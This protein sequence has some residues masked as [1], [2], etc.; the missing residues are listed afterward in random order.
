MKKRIF[1]ILIAFSCAIFAVIN[2]K[3]VVKANNDSLPVLPYD[4]DV[5]YTKSIII[6][7]DDSE[8]FFVSFAY[9]IVYDDFV[10]VFGRLVRSLNG[11]P[12][13]YDMFGHFPIFHD[14]PHSFYFAYVTSG[15]YTNLPFDPYYLLVDDS[16]RLPS[17]II[18]NSELNKT[19]FVFNLDVYIS[20]YPYSTIY[21]ALN[22]NLPMYGAENFYTFD[23]YVSTPSLGYYNKYISYKMLESFFSGKEQG[24][25]QGYNQ[26]YNDGEWKGYQ[27]G[28]NIGYN[29]GYSAGAGQDNYESGYNDG[30]NDGYNAGVSGTITT[31][32]F[33]SFIDS[34]FSIFN[35]EIFPNVKFIYLIFIPLGLGVLALIIKLI[36]G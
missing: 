22:P 18:Y 2:S 3:N 29:D 6:N 1:L 10:S 13:Y 27:D 17:D 32:W 4:L 7:I 31:N 19:C 15:Q 16:L 24:E 20:N 8:R 30:Y 12:T 23:F 33:T 28:Y 34:I 25:Q 35:V 36:R 9:D 26:G 21:L 11:S 5:D 14:Y